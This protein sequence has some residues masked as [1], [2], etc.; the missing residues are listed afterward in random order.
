M[1]NEK[2]PANQAAGGS[3]QLA[4]VKQYI[5]LIYNRLLAVGLACFVAATSLWVYPFPRSILAQGGLYFIGSGFSFFAVYVTIELSAPS[6]DLQGGVK[7]PKYI[8]LSLC[9]LAFL[10]LGLSC[11]LAGGMALTELRPCIFGAELDACSKIYKDYSGKDTNDLIYARDH[12]LIGL[13]PK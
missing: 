1:K 13:K 6:T 7:Y 10:L 8:M 4:P 2:K 12:E 5:S 3:D 9:L 11:L